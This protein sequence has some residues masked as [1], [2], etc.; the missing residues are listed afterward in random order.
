MR[1]SVILAGWVLLT[2]ACTSAPAKVSTFE[3]L[4]KN[5]VVYDGTGGRP[6]QA[7][8]GIKGDRIMAVGPLQEE[9]A[10]TVVDARGLAVAPGFI[11]MLS[12][13]VV[14]LLADGRSQSDIR[15]GV[16]TEIFGEGTSM[17]PLNEEMKR[18]AL[19]AQTD[20][21]YDIP[22][23]TLAEYLAHLERR[24]VSPNVA[25]F[26]GAATIRAHVLGLEDVQPTP[27]QLDQMRE[28]VRRENR[29]V[30]SPRHSGVVR[31]SDVPLLTLVFGTAI[32]L[33]SRGKGK[34]FVGSAG[35][36]GGNGT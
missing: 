20:I 36:N 9:Q 13:A 33:R 19:A 22:W 10:A 32:L 11:N 31:P 35:A 29:S 12:W 7:D 18:R 17:G 8:V 4:I 1:G 15:Q 34:R 24:G 23:T 25:S 26:V 30:P 16:T 27:A 21:T 3:V 14:S 2:S 28:L 5:G 6:I